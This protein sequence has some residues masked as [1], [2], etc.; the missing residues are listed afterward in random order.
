[1]QRD[2]PDWNT[3]AKQ[4]SL[5]RLLTTQGHYLAGRLLKLDLDGMGQVKFRC[6]PCTSQCV[7]VC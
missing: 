4:N 7:C 3:D 2:F 1:M 6:L 5:A